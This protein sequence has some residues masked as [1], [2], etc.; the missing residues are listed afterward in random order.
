MRVTRVAQESIRGAQLRAMPAN[1]AYVAHARRGRASEMPEIA[2]TSTLSMLR[3]RLALLT[4]GRRGST[5][6][7]SWRT[8]PMRPATRSGWTRSS[9]YLAMPDGVELALD[10]YLPADLRADERLPAMLRQ[11]R[12]WRSTRLRRPWRWWIPPIFPLA[13]DFVLRGYAW[14]DVDVRGSGAS[15]GSQT[16]PWGPCEVADGARVVDWIVAQPWS[17]GRVGAMGV[18][19]DGTAAEMLLVNGH[20]AVRAVAPRFSLFD[21]YADVGHPGGL[22]LAWFTELW[23]RTNAA[24]DAGEPG[25][26]LGRWVR[27]FVEG[28]SPT[29]GDAGR[30]RLRRH[31]AEHERNGDVH[32]G[33]LELCF[34]DDPVKGQGGF[35][36]ADFSPHAHAERIRAAGAAVF[37]YS[38][39]LDGAYARSAIERFLTLAGPEDRLLLGPWNHGGGQNIDP[40]RRA[41]RARFDHPGELLRFF[42]RHLL[43]G[44]ARGGPEPRVAY[45]TLVE[46]RWKHATSWPPPADP[47][48]L[49]LTAS[50]ALVADSAA[51]D[52]ADRWRV[53]GRA[54]TGIRSRWRSLMG[55]R[56]PIEYADRRARDRHCLVYESAPLPEPLEVSG[57]P[58][59][60][61]H[62]AADARDAAVFAYLEDVSPD[63]EIGYVTEGQL[64]ALHRAEARACGGSG[65]RPP[66]PRHSF[67]RADGAPLVPGEPARLR[68]A[69]LPTSYLFERGHRVRLALAGCDADH[70]AELPE[71][72]ETWTLLRG[73]SAP[74]HLELP[75][76]SR[77]PA[78]LP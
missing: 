50:G 42:D 20:P 47:L 63:G 71:A 35:R 30:S 44:A 43:E 5:S 23:Q 33:A 19:Y 34:R 46:G 15:G 69:L 28:V 25:R 45:Y 75:V 49:H 4:R 11:T 40:R 56:G 22:H 61:L 17:N 41:R 39:W 77:A 70:F 66:I 27:A 16:Y 38:G 10:L 51:P 14:L 18:S 59:V 37:S 6:D 78:G 1:L 12:Y 62:L 54:G 48:R 36:V 65:L 8:D 24:L 26:V 13:R 74:S 53:D 67:E 58:L 9:R 68:F 64:R 73:A 2:A 32:R 29:D 72:P 76:V 55:E 21:V 3:E 52:G 7:A 57:H 60:V 31:L